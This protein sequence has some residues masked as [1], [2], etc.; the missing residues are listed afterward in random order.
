[1]P[2]VFDGWPPWD[3]SPL[4]TGSVHVWG[5]H[6]VSS[7]ADPVL[8]EI[9]GTL[10]AR[11]PSGLTFEV[12]EHGRPS[13]VSNEGLD[14]NLSHSGGAIVIAVG[15]NVRVGVD[16]EDMSRSVDRSGLA[17]R[18]FTEAEAE[19]LSASDSRAF[20]DL[21]TKKEA[22]VKAIGK[23]VSMSLGSF[24]VSQYLTQR[25]DVEGGS[26][27]FVTELDPGGDFVGAVAIDRDVPINRWNLAV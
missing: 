4:A 12:G 3:R 19:R 17:R 24:E 9:L 22:V 25:V 16:V 11:D 8:R 14:F 26:R 15:V 21:W 23:G 18:F 7:R 5:A 27:W 1:M 10:L 2:A 6:G 20:F 13:L